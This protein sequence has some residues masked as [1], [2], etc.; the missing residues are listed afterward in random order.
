MT[1]SGDLAIIARQESA[2]LFDRF[3]EDVAWA[4]G[5]QLRA[6]GREAAWP[7]VIDIRT[8]HRALFF[9]ALPGSIPDNAEWAR[10]K[11]NV[12]ARYHRSTYAIGL[13]LAAK[14]GTLES[15]Y[16]LPTIDYAAHGGGFPITVG[17]AGTIGC[18]VISGLPQRDDHMLAV[19]SLCAIQGRNFV[20]FA[21]PAS[22]S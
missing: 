16:G 14:G 7:I 3:D 11:G 12:V 22:E 9:A 8:F 19:R 21:L 4:L 1:G 15:R 6:W 18:V 17:G 13:E 10:R 2:L 5:D 20:E